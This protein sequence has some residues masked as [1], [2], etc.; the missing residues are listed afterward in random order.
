MQSD[1]NPTSKHNGSSFSRKWCDSVHSLAL[2]SKR[3]VSLCPMH[4]HVFV[5]LC[6]F[7][8]CSGSSRRR[9]SNALISAGFV[10]VQFNFGCNYNAKRHFVAFVFHASL[11]VCVSRIFSFF[12]SMSRLETTT[13]NLFA[14]AS[15]LAL[16]FSVRSISSC[17]VVPVRINI[18]KPWHSTTVAPKNNASTGWKCRLHHHRH[19]RR[20]STMFVNCMHLWH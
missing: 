9:Q 17:I 3:S 12:C 14:F 11:R 8:R 19:R 6:C 16:P 20:P 4:R 18:H 7:G 2:C 10:V 5:E 13:S 15:S 1:S